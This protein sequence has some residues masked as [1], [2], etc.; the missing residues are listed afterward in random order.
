MIDDEMMMVQAVAGQRL[1]VQR[2]Y[3]GSVATKHAA[4]VSITRITESTH[5]KNDTHRDQF[6]RLFVRAGFLKKYLY[7]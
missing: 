5:V 2:Q 1:M 6:A 3:A 4:G 7:V